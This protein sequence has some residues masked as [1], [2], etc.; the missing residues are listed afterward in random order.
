[1][2]SY[3][4]AINDIVLEDIQLLINEP[5]AVQDL[6]EEIMKLSK[7]SKFIDVLKQKFSSKFNI[8]DFLIEIIKEN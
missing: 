2:N 1:M 4:P 7:Q 8:D 3:E 5:V 6:K